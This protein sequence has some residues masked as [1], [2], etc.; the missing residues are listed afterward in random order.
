MRTLRWGSG[1]CNSAPR[2]G[3]A[4]VSGRL[5]SLTVRQRLASFRFRAEGGCGDFAGTRSGSAPPP[6]A[7]RAPLA[8]VDGRLLRCIQNGNTA[9]GFRWLAVPPMNRPPNEPSRL[10]GWTVEDHLDAPPVTVFLQ[11]TRFY[12]QP[13]SGFEATRCLNGTPIHRTRVPVGGA[14]HSIK[15]G[16]I[17]LFHELSRTHASNSMIAL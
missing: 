10:A 3:A 12:P 4:Q 8:A 9:G 17:D 13:R 6:I 15:S 16:R 2:S 11:E 7:R 14:V 1:R 5:R